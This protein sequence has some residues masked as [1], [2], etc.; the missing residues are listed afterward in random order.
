MS[1]WSRRS[2][3]RWMTLSSS[4][5]W[6]RIVEYRNA[7]SSGSASAAARA[8]CCIVSQIGSTLA[9]ASAWRIPVLAAMA[10]SSF[11]LRLLYRRILPEDHRVQTHI[12]LL[13]LFTPY[14]SLQSPPQ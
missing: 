14:H 9:T 11:P 3:I 5:D 6:L 12:P 4:E 1:G 2:Q 10:V 7:A 8:S 13:L